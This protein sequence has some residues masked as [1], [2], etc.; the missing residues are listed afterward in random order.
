[1]EI[2][3]G[4]V[5]VVGLALG[6]LGGFF[7][8]SGRTIEVANTQNTHVETITIQN[9]AQVTVMPDGSARNVRYIQTNAASFP[10]VEKQLSA[11]DDFQKKECKVFDNR[12]FMGSGYILVYPV[13]V[14]TSTT[15]TVTSAVTN[16]TNGQVMQVR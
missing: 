15:N 10:E 4:I 12:D 3:I 5:F 2:I 16:K 8:G 6:G 14:G 1:M 7:L 9:A 11:L 13:Y